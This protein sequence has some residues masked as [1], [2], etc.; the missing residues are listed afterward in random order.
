MKTLSIYIAVTAFVGFFAM[1]H[2]DK[3]NPPQDIKTK[4]LMITQLENNLD[5]KIDKWYYQRKIDSIKNSKYS[6]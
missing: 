3:E 5:V 1:S 4:A 2:Q 6:E